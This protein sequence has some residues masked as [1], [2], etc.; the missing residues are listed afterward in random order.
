MKLF[1][2]FRQEKAG[3][4]KV[5]VLAT[6]AGIAKGASQRRLEVRALHAEREWKA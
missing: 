2:V 5:E 1:E 3:H 6:I 4:W